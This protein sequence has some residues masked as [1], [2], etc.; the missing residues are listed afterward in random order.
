MSPRKAR[1]QADKGQLN[2]K[3]KKKKKQANTTHL[4]SQTLKNM[5]KAV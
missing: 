1:S 5:D 4:I 3:K 2:F